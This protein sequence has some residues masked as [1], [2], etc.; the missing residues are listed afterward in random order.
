VTL[1]ASSESPS[2]PRIVVVDGHTLNP[3]DLSWE[4]LQQ[5]GDCQLHE[6]TAPSQLVE[7]TADAEIVITNKV[8]ISRE[9]IGRLPKLRYIGVTATGYN[10]VDAVAARE[11][12]ITVTNVPAYGTRSVAQHTM[13]LLLE[14]TQQA[15]LHAAGVRAGEWAKAKD[16]CYWK[17]P[18]I[19]LDGLTLGIVGYGRIGQAV[20]RLGEAF[21]MRILVT[22]SARPQDP[23]RNIA[24]ADLDHLFRTSDVVS[25]HCPLTPETRELV[26]ASRLALMKPT[27]F[28]LN[29]S[30]GALVDEPALAD[31][32]NR[33]QLAGAALDVLGA[34]PPRADNPLL[35]AKNCLITPHLA[36]A[37]RAARERLLQIAVDNTRAFLAGKPQNVVNA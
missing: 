13:A 9:D 8:V 4:G 28:L 1:S 37:T 33:G 22:V 26:N 11:R 3:G 23:P 17:T 20:A 34:E 30:R 14:L 32:L 15:G 7:R 29:T 5:L 25:L 10:I 36:W 18:L 31:A 19:E 27:A 6:R 21:G 12:S 35:Q 16:W 2:R 24:V